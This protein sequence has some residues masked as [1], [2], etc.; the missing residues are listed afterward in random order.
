MVLR[1][2]QTVAVRAYR[3]RSKSML[4]LREMISPERAPLSVPV[5]FGQLPTRLAIA[6]AAVVPTTTATIAIAAV[7]SAASAVTAKASATAATAASAIFAGLGF[8]HLQRTAA[9]FLAI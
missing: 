7:A 6:A 9:D 5:R 2:W 8:V 4:R 3:E 1:T